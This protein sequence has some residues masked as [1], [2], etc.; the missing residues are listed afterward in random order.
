MASTIE[1]TALPRRK[2]SKRRRFEIEK[3]NRVLLEEDLLAKRFEFES[4][5]YEAHIQFSNVC[6]MSCIMCYDGWIP[7]LRKMSPDILRKV[8]RDLAPDLSVMIPY[9]GSEPLIVTWEQA[10]AL[11]AENSIEMRLT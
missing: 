3:S 1:T 5:P 7:P 6:N 4:R 9:G 8:T 2:V 10:H 11:A